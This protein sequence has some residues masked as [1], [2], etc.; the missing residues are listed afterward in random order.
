MTGREH[1]LRADRAS[2][3]AHF[4]ADAAPVLMVES[5]DIVVF[6][7]IPDVSWGLEPPTSTTAPRRKFEPRDPARDN[8]PCL[9]GPVAV[10][11]VRPG[12]VLE[13]AIESVRPGAWGWTYAGGSMATPAWNAVLG[14][15]DAPLTLLRWMLD[16]DRRTA[17]NQHGHIR[18]VRPFPGT[19]GLAPMEKH[20][21]GWVPRVCGGNM[22]CRELVAGSTLYLPVMV[23]GGMLS[24]GDGHA[25]QGDG[26][27]S[28]TAIE[29]MLEEVRVRL[30]VRKDPRIGGP[31]VRT[32]GSDAE[33]PK[34]IT[35]GFGETLDVAA[36]R[37]MGEMLSLMQERL[38][39]PRAEVLALAS[40]AV[41]LRVTQVVNP[42]RGVHAVWHPP[43]RSQA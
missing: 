24:I 27:V 29:C 35:L 16:A 39:L 25:A 22:D 43:R 13:I 42:L 20:A 8:G 32:A 37:A 33:P 26:E 9:C 40:S 28:G 30:S 6:S 2:L 21:S 7:S 4:A 14:I 19:I 41:S 15:G 1:I 12:D 10:R 38:D 3:H 17:T 23:E 34:W 31:R 36:E 5:G 11:G 18:D